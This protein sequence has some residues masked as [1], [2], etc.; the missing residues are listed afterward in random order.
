MKSIQSVWFKATP[1]QTDYACGW[2]SP[3]FHLMSWALS[4]YQLARFFSPRRI[5]D[6][7]YRGRVS[8]KTRAALHQNPATQAAEK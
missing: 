1:S 5:N 7:H 8:N 2:L 6:R 3:T 4:A